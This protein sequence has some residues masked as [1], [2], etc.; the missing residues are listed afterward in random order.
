MSWA[1]Y[2]AGW[3]THHGGVDPRSASGPVR[4]WLRLTY[5][6]ARV[7]VALRVSPAS[8]TAAGVVL[9]VVVPPVA[10]VR[11][12]GLFAAAGLVA[13]SALAD[14]ADGAVAIMSRRTSRLGS[15]LDSVADRVGEA[16]WLLGLWAIGA[17]RL[18]IAGCL[19]LAW[20]YEYMRARAAAEGSTDIGVVTIAERPTR[21]AAAVAA[22]TLGGLAWLISP[23]LT[24][25]VATIVLALWALLGVLGVFKLHGNIRAELSR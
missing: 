12:P 5:F 19:G 25:G 17:S 8:V 24:P 16:A 2:S 22:F 3:A 1:E 21:V 13:A 14:S 9:A 20:L 23:K 4:G 10:L 6:T 15:Y 11:G 7:L 18:L